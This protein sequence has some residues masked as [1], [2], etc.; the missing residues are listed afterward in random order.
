MIPIP[1]PQ[2]PSIAAQ[3]A[4]YA[5]A[6]ATRGSHPASVPETGRPRVAA[7]AP[8]KR[9]QKP[10][11]LKPAGAPTIEAQILRAA[12]GWEQPSERPFRYGIVPV[13]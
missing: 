4:A 8:R 13:R 6:L 7:P 3:V 9:T 5:H 10:R 11:A 1:I 2:L 12:R